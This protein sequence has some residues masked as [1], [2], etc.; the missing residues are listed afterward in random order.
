MGDLVCAKP[1]L[2][3]M[4]HQELSFRL[5]LDA[6]DIRVSWLVWDKKTHTLEMKPSPREVSS[7]C[8]TQLNTVLSPTGTIW[9]RSGITLSTMNSV[10]HLKSTQF[11][12]LKPHSIQKLTVK[13]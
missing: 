6:Q 5:L 11:S 8:N 9:K 10:L 3:V 7:P 13:R 12:L 1:V 4:M 2:L